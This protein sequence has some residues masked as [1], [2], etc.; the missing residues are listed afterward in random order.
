MVHNSASSLIPSGVHITNLN[1]GPS[2]RGVS[3]CE[4]NDTVWLERGCV[5]CGGCF[6]GLLLKRQVQAL[7]FCVCVRRDEWSDN[8]KRAQ[9]I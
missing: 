5:L 7:A 9:V 3:S 2:K 1:M 4:S 8:N 6:E